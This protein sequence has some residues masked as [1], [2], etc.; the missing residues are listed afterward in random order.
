ML[1]MSVAPSVSV[2]RRD[3]GGDRPERRI[4]DDYILGLEEP[5]CSQ[6]FIVQVL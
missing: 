2:P 5:E 4:K 3:T 1:A 6:E